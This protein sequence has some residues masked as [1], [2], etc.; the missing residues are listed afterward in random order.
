MLAR[1][2]LLTRHRGRAPFSASVPAG[3]KRLFMRRMP[4]G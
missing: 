3:L 1:K 4:C 2:M